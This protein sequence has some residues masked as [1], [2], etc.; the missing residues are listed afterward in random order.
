VKRVRS[1]VILLAFALGSAGCAWVRLTPEAEQVRLLPAA[2]TAGCQK[3]GT[4]ASTTQHRVG[5]FA[6]SDRKVAEELAFL[7]R[8]EAAALQG[9]AVTPLAAPSNGRQSFE[10]YRCEDR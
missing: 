10:V 4:V 2:E 7:A 1:A 5:V 8:N 9:N 3:V 6:R